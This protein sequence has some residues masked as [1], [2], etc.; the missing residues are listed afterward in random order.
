MNIETRNYTD[1]HVQA[2]VQTDMGETI[3]ELEVY[4]GTPVGEVTTH[5]V[6]TSWRVDPRSELPTFRARIETA[7]VL[8]VEEPS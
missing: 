5:E 1:G 3:A 8:T 2:I 6:V 4:G 7:A